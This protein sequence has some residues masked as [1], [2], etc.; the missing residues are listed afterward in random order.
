MMGVSKVTRIK[1][2]RRYSFNGM[3]GTLGG[4]LGLF[5]GMSLLSMV[6]IVFWVVK[7]IMHQLSSCNRISYNAKA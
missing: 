7:I 5:T 2:D 3:I 4:T 1:K 6:E